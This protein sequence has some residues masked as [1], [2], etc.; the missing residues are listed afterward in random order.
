MWVVGCRSWAVGAGLRPAENGAR[1]FGGEGKPADARLGTA[2]H[3]VS[4]AR[5]SQGLLA[6]RR[7][8]LADAQCRRCVVGGGC[9]VADMIPMVS[10]AVFALVLQVI[11]T[12]PEK[13]TVRCKCLNTATLG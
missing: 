7:G 4:Y 2:Q 8:E 3:M 9:S 6:A 10:P 5:R 11:E 13:G 1:R 12:F